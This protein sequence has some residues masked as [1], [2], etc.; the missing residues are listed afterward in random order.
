MK[1]AI[2]MTKEEYDHINFRLSDKDEIIR[3][4]NRQLKIARI[5]LRISEE[6]ITNLWD[7]L[8]RP[9]IEAAA[10]E[11]E[12]D[13]Y[14]WC[15]EK[16]EEYDELDWIERMDD[17]YNKHHF[18]HNEDTDWNTW[19]KYHGVKNDFHE[20]THGWKTKSPHYNSFCFFFDMADTD[21]NYSKTSL[22]WYSDKHKLH[23]LMMYYAVFGDGKDSDKHE[24][25]WKNECSKLNVKV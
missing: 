13:F 16:A 19:Y 7:T 3:S 1:E 20:E 4:L 8:N 9:S 24:A 15:E 5:E 25:F 21:Y 17:K 22:K 12:D 11:A 23:C 10:K 2:I 6:R 18:K 14:A